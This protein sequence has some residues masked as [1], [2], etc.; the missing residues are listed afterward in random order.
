MVLAH[1]NIDYHQNITLTEM[2]ETYLCIKVYLEIKSRCII[3]K[4]LAPLRDFT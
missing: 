2:T 3:S 4:M 1:V